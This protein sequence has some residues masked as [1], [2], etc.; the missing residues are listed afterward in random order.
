MRLVATLFLYT[1]IACS[2]T[3]KKSVVE[4]PSSTSS[5][6]DEE[7]LI[8]EG[9]VKGIVLDSSHDEERCGFLIELPETQQIIQPMNLEADFKKNGIVVWLKYRPIRPIQPSCNKG[10]TVSIEAIKKG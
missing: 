5:K 4:Q 1:L 8:K 10:I 9:F 3:S 6:V 2:C 7:L